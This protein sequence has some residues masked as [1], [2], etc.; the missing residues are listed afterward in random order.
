M[1]QI[2]VIEPD[3]LEAGSLVS[4]LS[5]QGFSCRAAKW[6]SFRYDHIRDYGAELVVAV[7]VPPLPEAARLFEW[8][9]DQHMTLPTLAVLPRNVEEKLFSRASTVAEDF[10][11]WPFDE[12]ELLRRVNRIVGRRAAEVESAYT[13]LAEA[14]SLAQLVGS[15]LAFVRAVEQ[16]PAFARAGAPVLITGETG[17]GKELSARAIHQLG[18]RRSC[19]FIAVDCGALP[20]DLFE[21]ELFGHARGAFTDAHR[22]QKGLVGMAEGGTLFLDEI[23][24][25]SLRVQAKLLRFIQE[26]TYKPLGADRFFTAD[27][28]IIAATNR[29]LEDCVHD[30]QF[31]SDLYFRLNVLRLHL[32]PLR[33]RRQD[34][35]SLVLHFLKS[36]SLTNGIRKTISRSALRLLSTYDWP[37]NVRE[38]Y[39]AVQRA[40]FTC[41]GP[42]LLPNHFS[43]PLSPAVE[44]VDSFQAGRARAVEAFERSLYSGCPP[45]A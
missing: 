34:I 32:P 30:K 19:P 37:G 13:K 1:L 20:D 26:R 4:L 11:F 5:P 42:Q 9:H 36:H 33:E 41:E 45:Q 27:V 31:R 40:V 39:N 6:D 24:A 15:D 22:D 43:L 44:I 38:L 29:S 18:N 12:Q 17:T 3:S 14:L 2:L 8:M 10:V 16:I 21:N 25:L 35:E 23:D 7:A 28:K